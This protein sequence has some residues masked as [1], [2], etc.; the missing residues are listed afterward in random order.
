MKFTTIIT[1]RGWLAVA[2][3]AATTVNAAEFDALARAGVGVSDNIARTDTGELDETMMIVGF[4]FNVTERTRRLDL[5][6]QSQ[7]DYIDYLDDTF[8]SEVTAGVNALATI[9]VI[10]ER[11]RWVIQDTFG[12]QLADPL[13]PARPDNR[14]NVN[15]LT[16]GPT[17][18]LLSGGRNTLDLDLRYSTVSFEGQLSDNDRTSATL[19]LG[20]DLSRN[21]GVALVLSNEKIEFDASST[22]ADFDQ[23]QAFLRISR[24]GTN[25]TVS[26]DA[27]YNEVELT[28][29]SADGPMMQLEW[30]WQVSPSGTFTAAA[31]SRYSDQGNIFRVNLL[32]APDFRDTTDTV[33]T[34]SPFLSNSFTAGYALAQERYS[35][36]LTTDWAQQ[37]FKDGQDID[38]DVYGVDLRF[39]RDLSRNL[40][41]GGRVRLQ[42][43][44]FKYLDRNDDTNV[45]GFNVGYRISD[46]LTVSV[47]F[48]NTRRSSN[49][50]ASD[51]DENRI[52]LQVAYMPVWSR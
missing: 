23:R 12:Q 47:D 15:F 36:N 2:V 31:G 22:A 27:G 42:R 44:E 28:D 3:I 43:R 48:L 21:T 9:V 19:A 11:M 26:L 35:V 16:T 40:F 5:T 29:G 45:Y 6:I 17:F 14:D 13:Q 52:F 4:D 50:A 37:D 7:A 24:T 34:N 33:V 18:S 1:K 25:N 41:V 49:V 8:D 39:Q 10:D 20:R 30:T 38:R 32:T 51:F 46:G